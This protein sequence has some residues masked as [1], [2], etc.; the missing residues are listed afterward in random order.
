V[1]SHRRPKQPSRA[2]I[3]LFGATAAA[4]VAITSQS[5][6][7]DPG[8]SLEEVQEEVDDLRHEAEVATEEFNAAEE[9]EEEL[10]AEVEELQ[11]A[12]ARGQEELNDLRASLGSVA[13]AQYR[14]GGLDPSVQLFLSADPDSYLDRASTLD[15]VSGNQAETLRLIEDRQRTLEQQREEAGERLA[16][17]EEIRADLNEQKD[18]VQSRLS[19]AQSL[20]NTLTAEQQAELAAA[21]AAAAAAAADAAAAA[22]DDRAD[23]SEEGTRP[24][25]DV[26]VSGSSYGGSALSAAASKIGAPYQWAAEGPSSFD[27]S[28][29]TSWAYNQAGVSLPRTSQGQ[30]GAGT[31][32]GRD[33]LMPGDLVF[34]YGGLTHVGLYAGN[35]QILH[36]PS[37]G[38]SVRYDDMDIMPFQFGVRVG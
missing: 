7:A 31:Q 8:Q 16:E 3:T 12:A 21:Q 20:L 17:L 34:Y 36:A 32:V 24:S 37:T 15:Q 6:Q 2:R 23:R 11:D 27:C 18:A 33:Q 22:A 29:L 10:Q 30:A 1:A 14:N 28:G 9:R 13:A 5:A 19:E 4:T 38:S 35:G 25:L 26:D